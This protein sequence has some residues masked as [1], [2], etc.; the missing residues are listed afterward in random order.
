M[1]QYCDAN[2]V[3]DTEL[4]YI[5]GSTG[6]ISGKVLRMSDR[7]DCTLYVSK[8]DLQ[9]SRG[10]ELEKL[11]ATHGGS[12]VFDGLWEF[13]EINY[14]TMPPGLRDWLRANA[15]AYAWENGVGGDYDGGVEIYD[16]ESGVG[17][18]FATIDGQISLTLEEIGKPERLAAA[19]AAETK[20]NTIS[21][22][23]ALEGVS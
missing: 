23:N 17:E 10:V 21:R 14:G 15:L 1:R 18:D 2:L 16:P 6:L 5:L 8:R 11:C 7:C 13:S 20:W 22:L 12:P 9:G 19:R 3:I 4:L